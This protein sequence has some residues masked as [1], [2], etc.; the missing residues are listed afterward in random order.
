MITPYSVFKNII[1]TP[2]RNFIRDLDSAYHKL[3]REIE[4]KNQYIQE[5]EQNYNNLQF[6]YETLQASYGKLLSEQH[7]LQNFSQEITKFYRIY[8]RYLT[9]KITRV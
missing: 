7:N 3:E 5:L 6:S 9:S 8:I 2:V 1:P 4:A